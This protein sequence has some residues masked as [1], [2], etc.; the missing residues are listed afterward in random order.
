MKKIIPILALAAIM[1]V[2]ACS[3]KKTT[4]PNPPVTR[5]VTVWV[6]DSTYWRSIV[7]GSDAASWKYYGFSSEDTIPITDDQAQTDTIWDIA[8]KRDE[9]KLNGG[10]SGSKHVAAIDLAE[11]GSADST[12]FAGV[13][14]TSSVGMHHWQEDSYAY[15]VGDW[16]I[17]D[18]TPPRS[19]I[20]TNYVYTLKDAEGKYVKFTVNGL[21]GGSGPHDM[22]SIVI[23]YVYAASGT[24]ISGAGI[25]DTINVGPDTAYYDFSTGE[26]V[27][28]TNPSASLDWDFAIASYDIHLNSSIFG[29]GQAA[30]Y[31]NTD[32]SNNPRTDFDS[33]AVAETQPQAY[34]VDGTGSPFAEWYNYNS[35]NHT[36]TS[37]EHV[38]LIK[39]GADIYKMQITSYY[40]EINGAPTSGWYTFR[41]LKLD[42]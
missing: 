5:S 3:D 6:S 24:D 21:Y 42:L 35:S 10:I 12:D 33:I 4:N 30:A 20:P 40:F 37:K 16:Y 19:V 36:L 41:W 22:G 1:A 13:T 27:T 32:D 11:A 14:D 26:M 23:R 8:F 38:Y 15:A 7:N 9:V 34:S 29:P 31:L 2:V 17:Y 28:P 18:M 25:T 39:V